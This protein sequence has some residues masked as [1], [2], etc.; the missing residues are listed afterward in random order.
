MRNT[1]RFPVLLVAAAVSASAV[2]GH[3]S[4]S[5]T[6]CEAPDAF[7]QRV[8]LES[9]PLTRPYVVAGIAAVSLRRDGSH[10]WLELAAYSADDARRRLVPGAG[11][12]VGVPEGAEAPVVATWGDRVW[13]RCPVR[14]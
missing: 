7:V 6:P 3:A 11:G 2:P 10:R 5:P 12:A 14:S 8:G 4:A 9:A 1:I 13:L